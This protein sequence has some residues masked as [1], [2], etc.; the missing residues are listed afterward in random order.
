LT[1]P[2]RSG[3]LS[4][5]LI[6]S[7]SSSASSMVA[8]SSRLM[9]VASSVGPATGI[10][11]RQV[12]AAALNGGASP[13]SLAQMASR[14]VGGPIGTVVGTVT[15]GL[16]QQQDYLNLLDQTRNYILTNSIFDAANMP[17]VESE[18]ETGP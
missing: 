9:P 3:G 4:P 15:G 12:V 14:V 5:Q 11:G 2:I 13:R 17:L 6:Q 1:T 8:F 16:Q 10:S 7:P 18:L